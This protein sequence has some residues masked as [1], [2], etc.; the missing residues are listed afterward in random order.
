M[1]FSD[2]RSQPDH[3]EDKLFGIM[4][5][6]H[7]LLPP[8]VIKTHCKF[9]HCRRVGRLPSVSHKICGATRLWA[10]YAFLIKHSDAMPP[11]S[12]PK[13]LIAWSSGKDS[14]WALHEARR[15]GDYDIVGALTTVTDAFARVSMHGV[16]EELLLA[17]VDAAGLEP[18][19]VRI[20]YPCPNETYERAM[21]AAMQAAKARGVSH[22]IFGDLF[23]E[24]VR[25]YRERQLAGTGIAPVFPLWQRSTAALARAMIEAGM[26]AHLA[27]VDLKK[28][29][30]SF[31]GQRF[32]AALLDALPAD[33][34]PCGEN[35]EFHSFVSAGP[36]LA[37]RIAVK[38][39]ETVER[40]G[41][42]FADLLAA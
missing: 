31:A 35:G 37:R 12:L 22:I 17:Q 28:L 42:A 8:N 2:N 23:L 34:D 1:I 41:F 26:E 36:M 13:T 10:F 19:I 20:P 30:A 32:D 14:A 18:I 6:P 9:V 3:V 16:R 15:A 40:D 24:D 38:V 11:L 21:A 7:A 39:G 5:Q 29:P 33:A 25:A 27:T 4:R